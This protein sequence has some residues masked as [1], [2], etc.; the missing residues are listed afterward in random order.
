M[1]TL[2]LI[3]LILYVI[4]NYEHFEDLL[5]KIYYK[6]YSPFVK[7]S[8]TAVYIK[9]DITRPR[10]Y[11]AY[12]KVLD[13]KLINGKYKVAFGRDPK[14]LAE[15]FGSEKDYLCSAEIT[16]KYRLLP[17]DQFNKDL[18]DLVDF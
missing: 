17:E 16:Y 7:I 14:N 13:D 11:G 10:Y 4:K 1:V 6:L 15:G 3:F 12:L 8:T 2:Q 5:L 18:Q 9:K